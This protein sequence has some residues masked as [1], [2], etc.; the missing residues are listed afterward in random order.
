MEALIGWAGRK[1]S[2]GFGTYAGVMESYDTDAAYFFVLYED[3]D[4]AA[5]TEKNG[6]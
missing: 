2:L 5:A 6:G 1:V 3:D 4:S